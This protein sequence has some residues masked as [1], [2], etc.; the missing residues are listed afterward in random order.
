MENE[1]VLLLP[2]IPG[3]PVFKRSLNPNGK[4]CVPVGRALLLPWSWGLLP[5]AAA[6][7]E[8]ADRKRKKPTCVCGGGA[9]DCAGIGVCMRVSRS[10]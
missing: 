9:Q 5:S 1:S 4:F 8:E 6:C 2:V 10:V 7:V 3:S